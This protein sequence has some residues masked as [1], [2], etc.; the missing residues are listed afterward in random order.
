MSVFGSMSSGSESSDK[1]SDNYGTYEEERIIESKKS[2]G[3]DDLDV[4]SILISLAILAAI[5]IGIVVLVKVGLLMAPLIF[6]LMRTKAAYSQF[7]K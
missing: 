2:T 4:K 6:K 7:N 1:V 5:I 3:F